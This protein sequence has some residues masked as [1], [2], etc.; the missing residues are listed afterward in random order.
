MELT[1]TEDEFYN[2]RA[3]NTY[4]KIEL[5]NDLKE[6]FAEEN[7]GETEDILDE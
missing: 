2:L 4:N 5:L 1:K 6:A 3:T 7:D